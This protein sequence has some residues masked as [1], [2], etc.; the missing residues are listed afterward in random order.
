MDNNCKRILVACEFTQI[1]CKAFRDR[2]H[3]AYSCD[4][5]PTEGNPGWHIQGDVLDILD[6][7]W[8]LMIAHPPCKYL[9]YAALKHWNQEGREQ[10]RKEAMNFFM[11][12][13]NAP[14]KKICVENPVGLLNTVFRS[15]DQTIHPYYF[16]EPHLKRTCL[17]LKNLPLLEYK[18]TIIEKPQPLSTHLR[19]KSKLF[20]GGEVKKNYFAHKIHGWKNRSRFWPSIAK[21][22]AEQW[23]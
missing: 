5:L 20:K 9:T 10:K 2:G 22:M 8:D 18:N 7:G 23:G 6:D 13:W 15:S 3:E 12:L 19:S 14:I 4:L 17:W 21:A 11:M 16:G 1:V